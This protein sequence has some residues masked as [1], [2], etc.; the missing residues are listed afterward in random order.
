MAGGDAERVDQRFTKISDTQYE[1]VVRL[2]G[3]AS[4]VFVPVYGNWDNKYAISVKND[5]NS[6][7]G[8]DFRTGGEDILAPAATG[9]YKIVVDFQR[10]KFTVTP[11]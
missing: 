6:V 9:N 2:T 3:G 5:P 7:N 10:G 1:L 11:Q 8:G 4:Y